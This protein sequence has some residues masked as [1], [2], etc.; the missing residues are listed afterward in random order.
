MI[1]ADVPFSWDSGP[2]Q[3]VGPRVLGRVHGR[4]LRYGT[5]PENT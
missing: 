4:S 5:D 2:F 1:Q 3:T